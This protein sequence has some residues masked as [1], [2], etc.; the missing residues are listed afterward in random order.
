MLWYTVKMLDL[1]YHLLILLFF[2]FQPIFVQ[3]I[4][5]A[6]ETKLWKIIS[7]RGL[8]ERATSKVGKN[9]QKTPKYQEYIKREAIPEMMKK[10]SKS[11]TEKRIEKKELKP[12]PPTQLR[13]A[14]RKKRSRGIKVA[15]VNPSHFTKKNL[16]PMSWY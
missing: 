10:I 7:T 8:Q 12:N 11:L 14:L 3:H 1:E 5:V 13:I 9:L 4:V 6:R 2:L 15:F 16:P